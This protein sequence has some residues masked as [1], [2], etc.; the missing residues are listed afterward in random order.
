MNQNLYETIE[1]YGRQ[2][3]YKPLL[4]FVN[5]A[6]TLLEEWRDLDPEFMHY[7][8]LNI[9]KKVEI[10]DRIRRDP[11]NTDWNNIVISILFL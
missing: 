1:R 10:D 6:N 4:L 11:P 8:I 9:P 7:L 3:S 2:N 5:L